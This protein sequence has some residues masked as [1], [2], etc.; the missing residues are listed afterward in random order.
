MATPFALLCVGGG[1]EAG[2]ALAKLKPTIF[3]T[4]IKLIILPLIFI[5]VAILLGFRNEFMAAT[6]IM[7]GAP[8][9]P[10]CYIM[11]K[12]MDNDEVLT[13]SIIVI[14][15]LLSAFTLTGIIY[16]LKILGYL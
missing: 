13:S 8:T 5:P 6:I 12:S 14:T 1:F 7:L 2:K 3:G 9:T 4:L 15:T 10:T 11:A 16:V